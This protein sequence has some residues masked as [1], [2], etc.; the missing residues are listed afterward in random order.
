MTK[1]YVQHTPLSNMR[2]YDKLEEDEGKRA[3][4]VIKRT[5]KVW[6]A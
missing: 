1:K 4:V 6:V 5:G 3:R 2:E